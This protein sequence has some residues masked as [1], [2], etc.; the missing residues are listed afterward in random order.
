[1][2]KLTIGSAVYDDPEGV[3]YT[4]QSLRLNNKDILD[5]IDFIVVDNHPTG[6]PS[7]DTRAIC[8]DLSINYIPSG[9]R[10]TT[11]IRNKIFENSKTPWTMCIDSHVLFEPETIKNLINWLDKNPDCEDL[12]QGPLLYDFFDKEKSISTHMN[13]TWRSYMYGIWARDERGE[14]INGEPFEIPMQGLGV[15]ACKTDKWLP[16]HPLFKGFGG[17]EGYIHEKFRKA[18]RKTLCLPF[19][20]WL[21]KFRKSEPVPY[22]NIVEERIH[23]YTIGHLDNGKNL[24][25]M[26]KHFEENLGALKTRNSIES[27]EEIFKAHKEDPEMIEQMFFENDSIEVA[28][29]PP[30]EDVEPRDLA[31][32]GVIITR[33]KNADKIKKVRV[34]PKKS[35]LDKVYLTPLSVYNKEKGKYQPKANKEFTKEGFVLDVG[36]AIDF[37]FDEKF[38][39]NSFEIYPAKDPLH[40]RHMEVFYTL[41]NK[42]WTQFVF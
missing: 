42:E 26:R 3:W 1:M 20:R 8:R 19:L 30:K 31:W 40:I 35:L 27:A 13:P 11:A 10:R 2:K 39:T 7:K 5:Q 4:Y 41:D 9:E 38:E 15:F 34:I 29:K 21:H 37:E 36:E 18:G 24:D 17:E 23:N 33:P 25:S 22:P 16:F 32:S 6:L 14:D 12:I 28:P